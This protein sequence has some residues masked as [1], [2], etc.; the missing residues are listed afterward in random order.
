MASLAR[1]SLITSNSAIIEKVNTW[2]FNV[3]QTNIFILMADLI[4]QLTLSDKQLLNCL[5]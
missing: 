4:D 2:M 1:E 5:L 3:I